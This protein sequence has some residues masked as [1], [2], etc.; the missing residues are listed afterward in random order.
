M[1]II[2]ELSRKPKGDIAYHSKAPILHTKSEDLLT[3]N[4]FGTI[5]YL[6]WKLALKPFLE[7]TIGKTIIEGEF[8]D[9]SFYFWNRTPRFRER[10]GSTEIDL[11][12]K[13]KSILI[14]VESKYGAEASSGTTNEKDRDQLKRNLEAGRNYV[15]D[16]NLEDFYLIFITPDLNEPEIARNYYNEKGFFWTNWSAITKT[17]QD[18][19]EYLTESEKRLAGDL[20]D[21]LA[22]KGFHDQP[23]S[24]PEDRMKINEKTQYE[25]TLTR[26]TEEER[27]VLGKVM[28]AHNLDLLRG[29]H[30][31][32]WGTG[33]SLRT[34]TPK[35][36]LFQ[37]YTK[38]KFKAINP[39]LS[40]INSLEEYLRYL[41]DER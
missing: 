27:A 23:Y 3:A 2:Y 12:I 1:S 36:T 18:N 13:L 16:L 5:K 31:F 6:N 39:K 10:E 34:I 28:E 37:F 32:Y 8:E 24:Q 29:T 19:I 17:L 26:L 40:H 14:F 15:K 4:V 9:I 38:R 22:Y 33:F 20:I 11:I 41:Q 21:Y 25:S 30:G 35:E 7:N